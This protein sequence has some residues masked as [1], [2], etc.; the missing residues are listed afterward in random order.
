MSCAG[1]N[2]KG[3]RSEL[4]IFEPRACVLRQALCAKVVTIA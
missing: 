2:D 1:R 3:S 4:F